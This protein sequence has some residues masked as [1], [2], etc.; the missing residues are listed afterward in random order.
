VPLPYPIKSGDIIGCSGRSALSDVINVATLG[1]PRWGISH[2]GIIADYQGH[3][4]LFESTTLEALPDEI[5]GNRLAGVQAHDLEKV[6]AAYDGRMWLYPL[7]RPLFDFEER[8]LASFL[9]GMD[10][11]PYSEIAAVRSAGLGFSWFESLLHPENLNSI[12]CSELVAAARRDIG[13]S[14]TDDAARLSPNHLVR[15]LRHAGILLP[16]RRLK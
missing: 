14:P 11:T 5:S 12:F 4:C 1:V 16:P 13:I 6:V 2:V 9:V 8:R 7:S 3:K 15:R 10:G